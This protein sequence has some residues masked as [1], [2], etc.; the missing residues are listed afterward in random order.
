MESIERI[1]KDQAYDRQDD[2][3]Q[4]ALEEIRCDNECFHTPDQLDL[5]GMNEDDHGIVQ[6]FKCSCGKKIRELFRSTDR[7]VY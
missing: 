2:F 4:D 6:Y 3:L 1:T 5:I 7:I